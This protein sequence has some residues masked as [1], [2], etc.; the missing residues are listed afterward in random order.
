M[1]ATLIAV[2]GWI[3]WLSVFLLFLFEYQS[4]KRERGWDAFWALLVWLGLMG[5]FGNVTL[6]S[7]KT[8][9]TTGANWYWMGKIAVAYVAIGI[10][11]AFL[12]WM[13]WN[14]KR[15]RQVDRYVAEYLRSKK[16]SGTV[17]PDDLLEDWDNYVFGTAWLKGVQKKL[18][19]ARKEYE[20]LDANRQ[21]YTKGPGSGGVNNNEWRAVLA[22]DNWDDLDYSVRDPLQKAR[23]EFLEH[24][25]VPD[26]S[27]LTDDFRP[28]WIRRASDPIDDVMGQPSIAE[29]VNEPEVLKNVNKL[30]RWMAWWFVDMV[31]FFLGDLIHEAWLFIIHGLRGILQGI[32]HHQYRNVR[33]NFRRP[34]VSTYEVPESKP[35]PAEEV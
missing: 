28:L 33:K 19:E 10:I 20:R 11:W 5:A 32:A 35:E 22:R 12:R 17:I 26:P 25:D 34:P 8:F 1:I 14:G 23:K 21:G 24:Y 3:F 27:V 9:V 30:G 31:I 18:T 16:R 2:G 13:W 29:L 15:T 7:L 4:V 6:G